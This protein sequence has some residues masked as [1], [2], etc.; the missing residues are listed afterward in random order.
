VDVFG[1]WLKLYPGSIDDDMR[2]LNEEGHRKKSGEATVS[3]REWVVLIGIMHVSPQFNQHGKGLWA[4][5]SKGV[6][7]AP[8]I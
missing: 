5:E 4:T 8:V 3:R 7:E 6:T 2:R 1:L